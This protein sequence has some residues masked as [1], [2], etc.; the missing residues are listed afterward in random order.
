MSSSYFTVYMSHC[1][2]TVSNLKRI[3]EKKS[4][5][6]PVMNPPDRRQAREAPSPTYSNWT[7]YLQQLIHRHK[8]KA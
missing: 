7:F 2:A 4:E 8:I 5:R 3:F 1:K 6:G